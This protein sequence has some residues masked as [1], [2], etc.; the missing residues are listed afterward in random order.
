MISAEYYIDQLGHIGQLE[1]PNKIADIETE[2][3]FKVN[4]NTRKITVPNSFKTLAMQGDHKAETIWFA[5]DR[6]FDGVDLAEKKCAIQFENAFEVGM[7]PPTW[8]SMTG[9]DGDDDTSEADLPILLIG[10]EIPSEVTKYAGDLELSLRFFEVND[11]E[12]LYNIVTEPAK[13]YI[14]PALNVNSDLDF[15][16]NGDGIKDKEMN[17]PKNDLVDLVARIEDVYKNNQGQAIDY[18]SA[19]N[20]P[21]INGTTLKGRLF[22]NYDEA[23]ENTASVGDKVDYHWIKVAYKDIVLDDT[24]PK[25]NGVPLIGDKTDAQLGI[26]VTVDDKFDSTSLNPVQNKIIANQVNTF[27]NQVNALNES[28]AK[29]WEEMDGMT[30]IPLSISSFEC[31]PKLAEIGS[32]VNTVDF[33]WVI[34]GTPTVLKIN[35]TDIALGTSQITLSD[36][37]LEEDKEFTLYAE[38]RKANNVSAT[39][40]L[41]FVNKV[42][43]GVQEIPSEYNTS[44]INKL[45]GQLQTGKEGVIDVVANEN[46]YIYYA[47]PKSYEDLHGDCVFTSGGFSGGFTK[48]DTISYIN[49]YGVATDYNIWKS[50]NA[51]LGQTNIIIS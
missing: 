35:N 7:R 38:D 34:G 12:I 23:Q 16:V 33:T 26:K 18:N 24:V 17:P 1:I 30:F 46:Q 11:S 47:L 45:V 43:H 48:I 3:I 51:N 9:D 44:F 22:T 32:T 13:T 27:T 29:L 37:G 20:K 36:L 25:I 41:L 2:P 28:V 8:Q 19:V 40:Q 6:W 42:F 39:T 15:D 21:S 31:E 14:K 10:W 5:V 49:D 50:D 4:L